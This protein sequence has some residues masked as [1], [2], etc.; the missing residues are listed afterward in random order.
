MWH[1]TVF[2]ERYNAKIQEHFMW[3]VTVLLRDAII[4][5]FKN[6]F[7]DMWQVF[8]REIQY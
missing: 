4:T 8:F 6:T 3:H 2:L 5:T 1:V 7:C